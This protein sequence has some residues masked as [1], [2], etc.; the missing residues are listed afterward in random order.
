MK[1]YLLRILLPIEN[2]HSED[3]NLNDLWGNIY[4]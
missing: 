3:H 2:F 1:T 4:V